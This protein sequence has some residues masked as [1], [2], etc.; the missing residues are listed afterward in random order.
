MRGI[1]AR[2]AILG[3]LGGAAIASVS[4][5]CAEAQDVSPGFPWLDEVRIGGATTVPV[6]GG[7]VGTPYSASVDL[8]A[9]FTPLP[10]PAMPYDPALAWLFSPRPLLGVSISAQGRT[11]TGYA[12]LAWDA[13]I[14]GPYFAEFSL[15]G[16]VHDQNLNQVYSDRASPLTTRFLF[17]ESF[18]I[19]RQFGPDWRL[20]AFVDHA[21]NGDLADGNVG[22]NRVGVLLGRKFGQPA[23]AAAEAPEGAAPATPANIAAFSWAGPY[24]GVN[25]GLATGQI[26]F[27]SPPGPTDYKS[28]SLGGETGYNW[29]LGVFVVGVEADAAAQNLNGKA[30]VGGTGFGV[31][32]ESHWLATARGRLGVDVSMPIVPYRFLVYGTGGAAFTDVTNGYC[33]SQCATGG[34]YSDQPQTRV[35]WTAGGGVEV[36]LAPNATAKLEYLY[37]DFGDLSFSNTAAVNEQ[38]TFTEQVIRAG[39]NFK[40]Y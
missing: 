13:P 2:L 8:Q 4:G 10:A 11:D 25:V 16:L 7:A 5:G 6:G 26:D 33:L 21:S 39:M 23:T 24:L 12:A 18:A 1:C 32:A 9:L 37:V 38:L 30:L 40:L 14:I 35:G 27:V 17:H 34:A 15:G 19:G 28:V 31:K 3:A 22:L 20:L 29:A 36:P